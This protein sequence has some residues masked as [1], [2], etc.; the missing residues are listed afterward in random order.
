[1]ATETATA[2]GTATGRPRR[3]TRR[4][5]LTRARA[6]AS[7]AFV[8]AAG[9]ACLFFLAA[10]VACAWPG[11]SLLTPDHREG[12]TRWSWLFLGFL[13][14]AF[15]AY[16]AGLFVIRT[17]VPALVPVLALAAAIQLVPLASPVLLSTDAYTYWDYGRMAAVHG[18]NPYSDN[19]SAFPDDPAFER[20]GANW[21]ET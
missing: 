12:I 15:L 9:G 1:M 21:R 3:P 8:W 5:R 10:A 4:P 16:L 6:P 11:D 13:V 20:M 18:A 2:T 19:P 17:G 7:G 14:A